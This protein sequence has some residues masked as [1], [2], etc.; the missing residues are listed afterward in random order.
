VIANSTPGT[1]GTEGSLPVAIKIFAAVIVNLHG[2]GVAHACSPFDQIDTGIGEQLPVDL[3][4]SRDF[5]IFVGDQCR[6][7]E[8]AIPYGPT[9]TG[10]VFE[11]VAEMARVDKELLRNAAQIYAGSSEIARLSDGNPSAE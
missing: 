3:V 4:E 5:A 1:L 8:A 11:V 9:E 10:C 2:V 7:I 6:P